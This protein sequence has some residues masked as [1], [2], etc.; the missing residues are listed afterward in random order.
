MSIGRQIFEVPVLGRER[1]PWEH[2]A[3]EALTNGYFSVQN[4]VLFV[5]FL[6]GTCVCAGCAPCAR[7]VIL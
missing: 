6:D 5:E 4:Q 3:W 1:E 7:R 2:Q